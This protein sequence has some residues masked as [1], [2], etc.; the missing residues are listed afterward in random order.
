MAALNSMMLVN[1]GW[2]CLTSLLTDVRRPNRAVARLSQCLHD[3]SG[4]KSNVVTCSDMTVVLYVTPR[5]ALA[6]RSRTTSSSGRHP[7]RPW[8]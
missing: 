1:A 2:R 4:A 7:W 5:S 3:V 6:C 8:P